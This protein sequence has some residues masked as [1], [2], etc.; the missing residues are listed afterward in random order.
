LKRL[1]QYPKIITLLVSK[2]GGGYN[3]T[4]EDG[5]STR[6]G[7]INYC[8]TTIAKNHNVSA[9]NKLLAGAGR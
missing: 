3:K 7:I 4:K 8:F 9:V 2:I 5:D 6:T 1:R